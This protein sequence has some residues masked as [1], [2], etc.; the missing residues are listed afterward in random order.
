M[1]TLP[2]E[3]LQLRAEDQRRRLQSSI[4]ELRDRV[5]QEA[6]LKQLLRRHLGWVCAAGAALGLALGYGLAG[7]WARNRR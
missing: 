6:D 2:T 1:S 7:T 5:R 3:D 4:N